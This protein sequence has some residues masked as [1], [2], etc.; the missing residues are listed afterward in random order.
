MWQSIVHVE[1]YVRNIAGALARVDP[2][3]AVAYRERAGRYTAEL[4]TLDAEIRQTLTTVPSAARKV[5]S[6]HESFTYFDKTYGV[7]FLAAKGI[8][9]ESEPSAA[10]VA[11]LIRQLRKEKVL[12][13]FIENIS[14]PRLA[15]LIRKE[16]GARLGGTLYSDALSA[17]DGPAPTYVALMRHNLATPMASLRPRRPAPASD[18]Q[19]ENA[20][21]GIRHSGLRCAGFAGSIHVSA[22]R[23]N[24][25]PSRLIRAQAVNAEQAFNIA[26][27]ALGSKSGTRRQLAE[28]R[29]AILVGA[30]RVNAFTLGKDKTVLAERQALVA[31]RHQMHFHPAQRVVVERAMSEAIKFDM[32]AKFAPEPLQKI[33]VECGCDALRV[34]IGGFEQGS[35]LLEIHTDQQAPPCAQHGAHALQ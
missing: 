17:A 32:C 14:D 13:V 2:A 31:L 8:S 15:E 4:R 33:Q 21:R 12:A 35:I 26:N 19:G 30:L 34:V 16:S 22:I 7:R 25:D 20:C 5:V 18:A 29:N 23:Q 28:L 9:N 6:S 24:R 3:N 11:R 1:H 10:D 27:H